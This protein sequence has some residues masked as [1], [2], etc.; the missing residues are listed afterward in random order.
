MEPLT[1][2]RGVAGPVVYGYLRLVRAASARQEALTASLAE[3]CRQHELQLSGVF[4]ERSASATVAFTGLLDVL[5]L[6]DTYG[7]VLPAESHLGPK[8]IAADQARRIEAAGARLLLIRGPRRPRPAVTTL[9]AR[10]AQVE[11]AVAA[12]S[13]T[14]KREGRPCLS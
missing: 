7:V 5:A 1:E 14:P 2:H 10:P 9:P 12:R 11:L 4:T 8:R 6:P 13:S 3:Y